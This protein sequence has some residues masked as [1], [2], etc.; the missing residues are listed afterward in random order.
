MD[1][2]AWIDFFRGREPLAEAVDAALATKEAA[3]CGPIE[4]ELRRGL[5]K[6]ER[7]RVLPLVAACRY[8]PQPDELWKE[9]GELGYALRRR[10]VT[11]KTLDLLIAAYATANR[12]SLLTADTDF[13][14]MKR[15]GVP[16]DLVR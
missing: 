10:G 4:T 2:S 11:V 7:S 5:N 13:A 9:A 6:S 16:L 15:A 3:I 14:A 8:L 12:C 1:T